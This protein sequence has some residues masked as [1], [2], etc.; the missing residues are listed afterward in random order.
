[1]TRRKLSNPDRTYAR[2]A[3]IL[4]AILF[5]W[6]A[7]HEYRSFARQEEA[8]RAAAEE[9]VEQRLDSLA[10]DLHTYTL[11][12]LAD[13]IELATIVTREE[14]VAIQSTLERFVEGN[15]NLYFARYIAADGSSVMA[16][17]FT[18]EQNEVERTLA[19]LRDT[20]RAAG[21]S[22]FV[23]S[24]LYAY[25]DPSGTQKY[26]IYAHVPL[27]GKGPDETLE[28]GFAIDPIFENIRRAEHGDERLVLLDSDGRYLVAPDGNTRLEENFF[29]G[30]PEQVADRIFSSSTDGTF[31]DD[32]SVYSFRHVMTPGVRLGID[33]RQYW[34][35]VSIANEGTIFTEARHFMYQWV[36]AF[37]FLA[38]MLAAIAM[39]IARM[40]RNRI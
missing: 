6:L 33:E 19:S 13:I 21:G 28:L 8:Y 25:A 20:S 16:G 36:A 22:G 11:S 4:L 10:D 14:P 38:L 18:L 24:R 17:E 37:A 2:A 3:Y 40:A 1:M 35:L 29:A 26:L 39:L 30:Y 31:T 9:Q 34:V 12:G 15:E 5:L 27:A 32:G 23:F 7:V